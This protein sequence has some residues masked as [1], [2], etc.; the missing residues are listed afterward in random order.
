MPDEVELEVV[1]V[2]EIDPSYCR[3][4]GAPAAEEPKTDD[5]LCTVCERFQDSTVCPVCGSQARISALPEDMRP[6]AAKKKK[7]S[8]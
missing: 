4:C 8:N 7:G 2:E 3:H 1:S 5:W 6:K